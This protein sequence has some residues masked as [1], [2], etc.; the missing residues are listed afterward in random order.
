MQSG[1]NNAIFANG[2]TI[3]DNS[4]IG[5]NC[6]SCPALIETDDPFDRLSDVA[7]GVTVAVFGVFSICGLF[8]FFLRFKVFAPLAEEAD[9][10]EDNGGPIDFANQLALSV[11]GLYL[12]PRR[13]GSSA[14]V[15]CNKGDLVK[16]YFREGMQNICSVYVANCARHS[17]SLFLFSVVHLCFVCT[18]V[19]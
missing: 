8:V 7:A 14:P 19:L 12:W 5:P 11:V 16:S 6:A 15:K 10:D 3:L 1:V 2:S 13:H 18:L 17:L 4:C 9:V